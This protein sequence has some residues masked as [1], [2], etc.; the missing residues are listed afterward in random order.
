VGGY[1]VSGVVSIARRG[2][3]WSS[4]R[5]V[6]GRRGAMVLGSN[7]EWEVMEILEGRRERRSEKGGAEKRTNLQISF[8]DPSE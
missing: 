1:L 2:K 7:R 3:V 5:G 4:S 8:V 6:M